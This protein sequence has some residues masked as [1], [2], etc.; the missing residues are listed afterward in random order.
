MLMSLIMIFSYA[1][2]KSSTFE[3]ITFISPKYHLNIR[4]SFIQLVIYN[5]DIL[6]NRN[7]AS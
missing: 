5:H 7:P 1:M 4:I 6:R 2:P 3:I